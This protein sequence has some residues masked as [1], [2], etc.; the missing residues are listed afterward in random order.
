MSENR[1]KILYVDLDNT[2]VDF[3]S[4][5]DQLD[6]AARSEFEGNFDEAPGI[7]GTMTPLP[8]AIEAFVELATL[9]DAYILS[10]A[11]WLNPS[12]WSDKLLWVQKY[13]GVEKGTPAHKR[14]ILSHNKNLNHGD[15]I[16]DDRIHN[17]VKDFTGEHIHFGQGDFPTWVEVLD[18]LRT[19][20]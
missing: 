4:G 9:F 19:R 11:P 1:K 3:R 16:V 18:Y 5:I 6:P 7:F 10:T 14:L 15:F 13:F 2:L 8:G 12:A 17:G 20:A